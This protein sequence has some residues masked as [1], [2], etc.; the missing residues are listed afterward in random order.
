MRIAILSDVHGNLEALQRAIESTRLNSVDATA[1]LGD[2]VGYGPFPNECVHLVRQICRFVV[3]G[4]HDAGGVGDVPLLHFNKEG[5]TAITWTRQVLTPDNREYLGTLPLTAEMGDLLLV[6]ASPWE[7][8]RW[9]Y[10]ATW[11]LATQIFAHFTTS[12]CCLGHTHFPAI[13]ADDGKMNTLYPGHRHIINPGSVGQPRDGDPRAAYAILD[14]ECH[15]ASIIRVPYDVASTAS[16]IRAAGLP[17]F[18][19]RRLEYGI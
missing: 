16:A 9:T 15:T 5:N 14:T 7:P 13:I 6:H 2:I 18:L 3:K 19:A 12:F 11:A 1:C 8:E 4:N 17:E 10:I